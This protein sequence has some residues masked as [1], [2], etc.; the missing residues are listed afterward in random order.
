MKK[1]FISIFV[2]F[3][4]ICLIVISNIS[5]D[6][7]KKKNK[8]PV[9]TDS[10]VTNTIGYK[11]KK[12]DVNDLVVIIDSVI[13]PIGNDM[14]EY[15]DFLSDPDDIVESKVCIG[16]GVEKAYTYGDVVVSALAENNCEKI[17]MIE[18]SGQAKLPSGVGIGSTVADVID[19]Y[20][21]DYIEDYDLY[22]YKVNKN[23]LNFYFTDGKVDLVE[24]R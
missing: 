13:V 12:V 10:K 4:F 15:V 11:D 16:S 24:I 5:V 19:A 6:A 3:S 8:G 1:R 17:Y 2:L 22:T 21:N 23:E 18:L 7:A 9:K 14:N 20:G